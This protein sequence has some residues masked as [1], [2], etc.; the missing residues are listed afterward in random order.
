MADDNTIIVSIVLDDGS[1]VKGFAKI[2]EKAKQT[3]EKVG[4]SFQSG[5]GKGFDELTGGKAS[6]FFD[7]I[8][9]RAALAAGAVAAVGFA[10]KEAF[11]LSIEGEKINALN[12][13]FD[14]LT[15]REGIVGSVLKKGLEEASKG[16]ID[17]TDLLKDANG[18]I[19]ILGKNASELPGILEISTK[20]AAL[21]GG[22]AKD[23]FEE[24]T[25]AIE[26]LNQRQLKNAGI[27]LDT[28]KVYRDYANTIGVTAKEL[29][30]AEQQT[31]L[32]NAALEKGK[33]VFQ[34]VNSDV[35]PLQNSVKGLG[36][37][38]HEFFDA[39]ALEVNSRFADNF[40]KAGDSISSFVRA[41]T[42]TKAVQNI[43]T[44]TAEIERLNSHIDE[45]NANPY[46]FLSTGGAAA[47]IAE[48]NKEIDKQIALLEKLGATERTI[49]IAKEQAAEAQA[50]IDKKEDERRGSAATQR[51]VQLQQNLLANSD[52]VIAS[53]QATL[54]AELAIQDTGFQARVARTALNQQTLENVAR[55]SL[56]K[57]AA[58]DKQFTEAEGYNDD[59]REKIKQ[60]IANASAAK[61]IELKKK[62]AATEDMIERQK[63]QTYSSIAGQ[64]STLMNSDSKELFEIGKLA[65]I[66]QATINGYLAVTNAFA[67]VPYPFNFAV[68]ALVG[69][70]AAAN[71]AK[72]AST[73]FGQG[74]SGGTGF[75]AGGSPGGGVASGVTSPA[76]PITS[77]VPAAQSKPGT[78][79]E[80]N[81]QGDVLD[82]DQ[83]GLRIVDLL[84]SA[85]DKQGVTV[86]T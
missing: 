22:T 40:K 63:L 24:I 2:E 50:E 3:G 54:T 26:T 25:H 9:S 73:Q 16:L 36:V 48:T 82:S 32:M 28:E 68:A 35:N 6:K 60:G 79:I 53:Q 45:I 55:E 66:S 11:D 5:L 8:S 39:I 41:L 17:T 12:A 14:L 74:I 10:L 72:I 47:T 81:I 15:A 57:I 84:N 38:F 49:Q 37:T 34:G 59:Q 31:A 80:V 69:V 51:N 27:I 65:A 78:A 70:A 83:T 56:L 86:T 23:K 29:T 1:I 7:L 62:T 13:Q 58:V 33:T 19:A 21:F 61:L 85:F 42:P 76:T 4:D 20:S 75:S 30:L 67:E 77:N 64:I 71:V 18:A 52:A 46:A 43:Q 44:I